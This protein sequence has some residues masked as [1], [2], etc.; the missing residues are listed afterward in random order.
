MIRSNSCEL[1]AQILA[2]LAGAG[3]SDVARQ[4][5]ASCE[6][7]TSLVLSDEYMK[8][9]S[10]QPLEQTSLPD[11]SMLW[12]KSQLLAQDGGLAQLAGSAAALHSIG[13]ALVAMAWAA[14]LSWKWEALGA[15][16]ATMR[17]SGALQAAMGA[18]L[19]IPL[20]MTLVLLGCATVAIAFHSAFAEEL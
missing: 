11:A 20:I 19:S 9:L 10:A 15:F 14:L 5:L 18:Q 8:T 16:L 13:F 3:L 2:L 17:G 4:H 7:C 12:L 1:E 6:T